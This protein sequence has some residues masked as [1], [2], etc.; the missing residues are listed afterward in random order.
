MTPTETNLAASLGSCEYCRRECC[1]CPA[2]VKS[3]GKTNICQGCKTR[4][5]K[6]HAKV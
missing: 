4:I 5:E 2:C 3:K 6:I 1:N